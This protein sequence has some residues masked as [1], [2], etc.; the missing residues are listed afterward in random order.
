MNDPREVAQ[1]LFNSVEISFHDR[2]SSS[3]PSLREK[4]NSVYFSFDNQNQ[5]HEDA[6]NIQVKHTDMVDTQGHAGL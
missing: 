6:M 3:Q 5:E 4:K 1:Q 2:E